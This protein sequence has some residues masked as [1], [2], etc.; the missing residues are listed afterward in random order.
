LAKRR[1]FA[2]QMLFR[3]AFVDKSGLFCERDGVQS[4]CRTQKPASLCTGLFNPTR[5]DTRG[6]EPLKSSN[7]SC[8]LADGDNS[9]AAIPANEKGVILEKCERMRASFYRK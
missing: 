3:V 5:K 9:P 2:S 7:S 4:A 1:Y 6:V 8:W